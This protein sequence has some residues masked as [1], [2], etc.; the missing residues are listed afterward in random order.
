MIA[1]GYYLSVEHNQNKAESTVSYMIS[2]PYPK[3]PK[4][5]YKIHLKQPKIGQKP[6]LNLTMTQKLV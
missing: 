4:I 2:V 3:S 6:V 5:Q 1:E